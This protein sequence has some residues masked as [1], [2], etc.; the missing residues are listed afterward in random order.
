MGKIIKKNNTDMLITGIIEDIPA[1]SHLQFDYIFPIINMTH[2]RESKID[3][4]DYTQ[5]ATYLEVDENADVKVLNQKIAGF[6]K[7]N[8]PESKITISLQSLKD[9]HLHSAGINSWMIVY[10]NPGNINFILIFSVIAI[11]ILLLACINF[12]NL[13]TA[14]SVLRTREIGVRKVA[15][16]HRKDLLIQFFGETILFAVISFF[17]AILIVEISIQSFNSVSGKNLT[18]SIF[19]IGTF[20]WSTVIV[21][22]TGIISGIYP[23]LFLSSYQ[24]VQTLAKLPGS[25]IGHKGSLRKAL[26]VIQFSF[27]IIL[28]FCTIT[29][30]RQLQFIQ[31]KDLGFEKENIVYFAGYGQYGRDYESSKNELLTNSDIIS[32]CNAFPPGRGFRGTSDVDWE[33]KDPSNST[34]FFTEM[35][36]YD[37]LETFGMKMVDG[38]YYSREYATDSDNYVINE[39]AVEAMGIVDPVGKKFVHNGEAGTI[40]G[41]VKNFHGGSLHHPIRPKVMKFTSEGF[42]ICV[43]FRPGKTREVLGF[44]EEKWGKFVPGFPF[45][46]NFLNESIDNY[47]KTEKQVSEIIQYFTILAIFIA[48]LGL[49]GLASFMAERKTKEIGIRK[50]LGAQVSGIVFLLTGEFSRWVIIASCIALPVGWYIMKGWL[51]DFAYRIEIDIWT[52]F[53][54]V[55]FSLFVAI[56]TV[57]YQSIKVALANPIEALRY[58]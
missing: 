5:F 48:C 38:R 35:V 25:I 44:L 54:S 7:K 41:V 26:V 53:I 2:W 17:I 20:L 19:H 28:V 10:P 40:I 22:L 3:S 27:T 23:A 55:I 31:N 14:K 49:F 4:W 43:R 32:I 15:G 39:A 13:S 34:Q 18:Y 45:R 24:P 8:N 57:G 21:V 12:M 58:E 6:V 11:C 42:F 37:Y 30:F 1:N 46:Y 9:I 51:E 36:D 33:G 50:V 56:L 47:Y 16:A 52:Y 29:I